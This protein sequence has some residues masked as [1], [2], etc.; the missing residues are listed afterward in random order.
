MRTLSQLRENERFTFGLGQNVYIKRKDKNAFS[1]PGDGFEILA[2]PDTQVYPETTSQTAA[3]TKQ[4]AVK[5]LNSPCT[6]KSVKESFTLI[7]H[8]KDPIDALNNAELLHEL[9]KALS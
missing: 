2:D 9:V 8:G 1:T 5:I 7:Y 3:M 6:H 4:Q